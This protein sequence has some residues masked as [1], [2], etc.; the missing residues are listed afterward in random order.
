M[1]T[2]PATA[3]GS[4]ALRQTW[5]S[6]SA[7][8]VL[9]FVPVTAQKR[10]GSSRQA[11]SSSPITGRPRSR[12]AAIAGASAGTPGLLTTQRARSSGSRPR[13]HPG[14]LRRRRPRA[15]P[16]PRASRESTPITRSPRSA[17]SRAAAW[18][19]RARPTTRYGPGGSGGRG[20]ES[21]IPGSFAACGPATFPDMSDEHVR[22]EAE[23]ARRGRPGASSIEIVAAV[24]IGAGVPLLWIWIGSLIQSSRG[25]QHVEGIDRRDPGRR[26]PRQLRR[27]S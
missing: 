26:H 25:A 6:S 12:A 17:S 14:R 2:L 10:F 15:L 19:E 1:P 27:S 18:P 16:R 21:G 13:R 11:S 24:V 7:T 3:T 9:P 22:L 4:P 20:F 23:D 8:V 5:P